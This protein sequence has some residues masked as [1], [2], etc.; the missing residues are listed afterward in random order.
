[1]KVAARPSASEY[2]EWVKTG[3]AARFNLAVSGVPPLTLAEL[4][5]RLDDI[6]LSGPSAYGWPPLQQALAR[7]LDVPP[8][9]LVIGSGLS[10]VNYV[11][12]SLFLA[13]GDEVVIEEPT[14]ALLVD[15]A[16]ELG[17]V[18]RRFPRRIDDGY[19]VDPDAVAAAMTPDTRLVILT[20]LHN[21]TNVRTGDDVLLEVG[22]HAARRGAHV[23]VDEVYLESLYEQP[24]PTAF[25]LG[26]AFVVTSGLTKAYGLGGLRCGW[27]LAEAEIA[28]RAH[29]LHDI[30]ANV[31]SHPTE[32]LSLV[33]LRRIGALSER[34]RRIVEPNRAA[35]DAFI[36]AR[37]DLQEV[38]P[39]RGT[40]RFP[41]WRGGAV[42]ELA[43][44]LW[45]HHETTVV[46]GRFFGAPESFRVGL[47]VAADDFGEGLRRLG[48]ALDEMAR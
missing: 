8:E 22:E 32:R 43:R 3:S 24:P 28:R 13:P 40:V 1:M 34:A 21:P 5:A 35:F 26:P 7:H 16:E 17:A 12:L 14:Y 9:C 41:R 19:R 29:R 6:E 33:A 47:G 18:V 36:A 30:V 15:A 2:M 20:N 39:P 38:R 37:D 25:R 23:L 11:A 48:L 10:L 4:G 31:P 45:E 42:D 44:I 27:I 46:P